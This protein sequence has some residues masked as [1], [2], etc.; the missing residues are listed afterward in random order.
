VEAFESFVAVA[1]EAENFA[2]SA[3]V[4]FRVKLPTRKA[5]YTATRLIL[6]A[7]GAI[8]RVS[9]R[10]AAGIR[11]DSDDTGAAE[12]SNRLVRYTPYLTTL[13]GQV[14]N[15]LEDARMARMEHAA[16]PANDDF[17]VELY[18]LSVETGGRLPKHPERVAV[19]D[20]ADPSH[21]AGADGVGPSMNVGVRIG[22]RI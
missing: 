2:A 18:R 7:R 3:G 14:F 1:L 20:L 22:G 10:A 21:R 11:L 4:K 17:P 19:D 13:G 5:A 12:I 6:V 8:D 15:W 9:G 16:E